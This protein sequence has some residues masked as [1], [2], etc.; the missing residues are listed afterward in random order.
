MS[1]SFWQALLVA[2][3]YDFDSCC[4]DNSGDEQGYHQ[5]KMSKQ[6]QS[7]IVVMTLINTNNVEDCK[8]SKK[9]P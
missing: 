4:S 5:N 8:T 6:I 1:G 2:R 7:K 9:I 3:P